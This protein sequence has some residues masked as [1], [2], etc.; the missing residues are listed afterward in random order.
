[1][2]LPLKRA[3]GVADQSEDDNG[4]NIPE[5]LEWR[6]TACNKCR[7]VAWVGVPIPYVVTS[8]GPVE[9]LR[10]VR[11]TMKKYRCPEC[12]N[13]QVKVATTAGHILALTLLGMRERSS[14]PPN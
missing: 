3:R 13:D 2:K 9:Q 4:V 14:T 8:K 11:G 6:L 10:V 7:R 12:G 1:M 5:R